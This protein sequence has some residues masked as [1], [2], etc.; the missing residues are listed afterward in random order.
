MVSSQNNG[1]R[2]K[3]YLQ[4]KGRF[5]E[6]KNTWS[7]NAE[8]S[9]KKGRKKERKNVKQIG[10]INEIDRQIDRQIDR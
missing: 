7:K 3:I 10:K 9:S 1:L 2:K 4:T 8:N 5:Y 6:Y